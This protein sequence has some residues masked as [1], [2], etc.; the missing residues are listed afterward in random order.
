M[1]FRS[2]LASLGRRLVTR[3]YSRSPNRR[4]RAP[5]HRR[6]IGP[7]AWVSPLEPRI[8]LSA[9][10]VNTATDSL[11]ADEFLSLREAIAVL[12]DGDP[13]D[14]VAGL[15]DRTLTAGEPAQVDVG[16]PFGTNDT[17]LFDASLDGT[18]IRF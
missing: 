18:P 16:E 17:V 1:L 15:G 11:A 5:R 3:C 6:T 8:L 7:A 14:G 12:N 2:W 13:S 10:T 9:V 4:L